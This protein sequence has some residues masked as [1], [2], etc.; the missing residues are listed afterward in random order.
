MRVPHV[1]STFLWNAIFR[2]AHLIHH[3]PCCQNAMLVA[4]AESWWPGTQDF[5]TA[6]TWMMANGISCSFMFCATVSARLNN[7]LVRLDIHGKFLV[8]IIL[9]GIIISFIM[10][11]CLQDYSVFITCRTID[12]RCVVNHWNHRRAMWLH[13]FIWRPS[14][15]RIPGTAHCTC[16]QWYTLDVSGF[17]E[18]DTNILGHESNTINYTMPTEGVLMLQRVQ[19][20]SGSELMFCGT[21]KATTSKN[22]LIA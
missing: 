7:D 1:W 12:I 15:E 3:R 14:K 22:S 19:H 20:Y 13:M 16:T 21:G 5:S 2:G 11:H 6:C 18:S 8:L 9:T 10:C 4:G 17:W